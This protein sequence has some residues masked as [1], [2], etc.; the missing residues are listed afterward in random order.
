V[1]LRFAGVT[2]LVFN[3]KDNGGLVQVPRGSKVTVE[4]PEN[5]ATGHRW[6]IDSID[7]LFL[8]PEGDIFLTG[9]QVGYGAGGVRKF[10][11]RARGSGCTSLTFTQRCAL[12]SAA[13]GSYK[14][15]VQIV[16]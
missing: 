8:V 12:K 14:L 4:L 9:H 6:K 1:I 13:I 11:Y 3:E 2:E 16:K 15:V 7:E 5:P 10:F